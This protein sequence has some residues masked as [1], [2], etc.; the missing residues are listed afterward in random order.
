[1]KKEFSKVSSGSDRNSE[2]YINIVATKKKMNSCAVVVAFVA[3]LF[4]ICAAQSV[5]PKIA[6]AFA[7]KFFFGLG[8]VTSSDFVAL[9]H[10][11]IALDYDKKGAYFHVEDAED[12][13]VPFLLQTTFVSTPNSSTSTGVTVYQQFSK[14]RCWNMGDD[15]IVIEFLLGLNFQIPSYAS[16]AGNRT[17]DGYKCELWSWQ[18]VD[19]IFTDTYTVAVRPDNG[20]V[21]FFSGPFGFSYHNYEFQSV[22]TADSRWFQAP[23]LCGTWPSATATAKQQMVMKYFAHMMLPSRVSRRFA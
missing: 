2:E 18:E 6:Q 10:G 17:I 19:F 14:D 21:V 13:S 9:L 1:L 22:G 7:S 20:A 15:N 23:V 16:F 12:A 3:L 5:P 11:E 4:G 8:D